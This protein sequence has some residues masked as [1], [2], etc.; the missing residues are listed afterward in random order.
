MS[1][2]RSLGGKRQDDAMTFGER[3]PSSTSRLPFLNLTSLYDSFHFGHCLFALVESLKQDGEGYRRQ[4]DQLAAQEVGDAQYTE[5]NWEA[6][7]Y[8]GILSEEGNTCTKCS[9]T[10]KATLGSKRHERRVVVERRGYT[11]TAQWRSRVVESANSTGT[12]PAELRWW[13]KQGEWYGE[14]KR[15]MASQRLTS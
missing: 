14:A 1:F 6:A 8:S 10:S 7:E 2:A 5:S 15:Q 3:V 12:I 9:H 13:S 4:R 11:S